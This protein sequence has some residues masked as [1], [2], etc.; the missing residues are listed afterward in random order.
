MAA[1]IYNWPHKDV[2]APKIPDQWIILI[3]V[4]NGVQHRFSQKLLF[5][6]CDFSSFF[7]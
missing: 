4:N 3:A 5:A 2:S 1:M 6:D 7:I